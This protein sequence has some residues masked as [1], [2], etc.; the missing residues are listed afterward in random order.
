[1]RTMLIG[2]FGAMSLA[3]CAAATVPV[4]GDCEDCQ[5]D[6]EWVLLVAEDRD[7]RATL[8][9]EFLERKEQVG[10]IGWHLT[11]DCPDVVE[12]YKTP[13]ELQEVLDDRGYDIDV[14]SIKCVRWNVNYTDGRDLCEGNDN[15]PYDADLIADTDLNWSGYSWEVGIWSDPGGNGCSAV[16]CSP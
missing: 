14:D 3:G 8:T 7:Q 5:P 1:M 10:Q 2:L 15:T 13:N 11:L 6:D 9:I 16:A 12:L 4:D